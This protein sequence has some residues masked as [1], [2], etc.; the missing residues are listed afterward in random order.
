MRILVLENELSSRRG[1]QEIS[2]LDVCRGLAARGHQIVVAYVTSGDLEPGYREFGAQLIRVH[3]YSIDRSRAI[4]SAARFARSLQALIGVA[5]DVIY[6]N[7]YLDSLLAAAARRLFRAPFVCHLRLPPPDELCTQFRIGMQQ[8]TRCIAISR[9]T[10]ADWVSTGF[11]ADRID[12]VYNGIDTDRFARRDNRDVVR[13]SFGVAPGEPLVVYAGRLHPSK[14]IEMLLDGFAVVKR[15]KPA[16]K[17]IAAGP[18]AVMPGLDGQPRRYAAELAAQAERHGIARSITWIDHVADMPA[19]LTAADVVAVPSRWSEPF[20]RVI[21]EAMACG[22]PV[23]ATRVGGIPEILDGEFAAWLCDPD[24]ADSVAAS[25]VDLL[26]RAT[27]D[28]QRGDRA[29]AHVI[30]RFTVNR[31]VDGVERSLIAATPASHA[32]HP[33]FAG[34]G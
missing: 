21:V 28:P 25:I 1:G 15:A 9:Q 14:G 5:P 6:A 30:A 4:A 22:T 17:L 19:L 27:R 26:E 7:Q 3:G 32:E 10:K 24:S 34:R 13:A 31:M 18:A 20:G 2:L 33:A 29:R 12:V 23:A 8:A 16:A 11:A